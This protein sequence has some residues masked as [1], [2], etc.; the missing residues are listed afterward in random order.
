MSDEV[1]ID[2]LARREQQEWDVFNAI[3]PKLNKEDFV[4]VNLSS[5]GRQLGLK[6]VA[7]VVRRLVEAGR[8]AKLQGEAGSHSNAFKL[9]FELESI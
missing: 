2:C 6:R 5:I 9:S 1:L 4:G 3:A 7:P 8:I